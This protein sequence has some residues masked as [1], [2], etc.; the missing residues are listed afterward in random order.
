[1]IERFIKICLFLD[2]NPDR[3]SLRKKPTLSNPQDYLTL[4]SVIAQKYYDGY[5]KSVFPTQPRTVPDKMVGVVMESAYGYSSSELE[6]IIREHQH[7]MSAE[8]CVGALLERYLD[9]V[10]R[11]HGWIWCCGDFIRGVD[12]IF[13]RS[14]DW[15]MLQIKNRDNTENSSGAAIRDGTT[16]EKW[17]RTYSKSGR[18]NWE[19]LPP[20]MQGK[21]LSE[22][23][24]ITFV[25]SYLEDKKNNI[26]TQ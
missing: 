25:R 9:S 18:T 21:G 3:L 24:F 16:I 15:I 2:K 8:N 26:Y 23:N 10:L 17:F 12:F 19:K 20:L 13:E 4:L 7:S 5:S 11:N 14:D 6:H 1:M 22:A